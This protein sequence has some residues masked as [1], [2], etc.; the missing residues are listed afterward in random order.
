MAE[1]KIEQAEEK[2]KRN[3]KINQLTLAEIEK[4]LAGIKESMGGYS[5][6]YARE[7]LR[8]KENLKS[9]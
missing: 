7:L 2:A 3:K 5:S 1:E 4:K 6:R 9:R 8:R